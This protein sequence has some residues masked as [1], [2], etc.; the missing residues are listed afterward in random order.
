M[1]TKQIKRSKFRELLPLQ[2]LILNILYYK[3]RIS[4][5]SELAVIFGF[6]YSYFYNLIKGLSD[7]GY[8]I[9]KKIGRTNGIKIEEKGELLIDDLLKEIK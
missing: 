4:N 3:K 2:L 5:M 1:V 6:T 8:I 9:I 7:N